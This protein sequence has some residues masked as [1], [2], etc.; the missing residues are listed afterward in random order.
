MTYRFTL[1]YNSV[2]TEVEEPNGWDSFKSE[3]KRDFKSHGVVF[4]YTSGTLK[5]G[6]AD[7]RD[8]LESA[9]QL[10]GFD[11]SVQLAIDQRATEFDSWTN[12]FTGC[13]I[14][15]NR[16]LTELYF[17]V[18]F[19]S[20]TFQQQTVNRLKTKLRLDTT[21]DLDGATLSGSLTSY[22]NTWHTMRVNKLS[23]RNYRSQ[24]TSGQLETQ[25]DTMVGGGGNLTQTAIWNFQ[26]ELI[27]EWETHNTVTEDF[28]DNAIGNNSGDENYTS[29]INGELS[30]SGNIKVRYS[31][32]TSS[33][34]VGTHSTTV[35]WIVRHENS[36]GTEIEE[37]TVSTYQAVEVSTSSMLYDSGIVDTTFSSVS[38]TN[39]VSV[40]DRVFLYTKVLSIFPG[41]ATSTQS[42]ASIDLYHVTQTTWQVLKATENREVKA[43][44]I[45]DVIE[46]MLYI[47]TGVNSRLRSDFLATT[48]NGASEDGCGSLVLLTNGAQLRG[49][50]NAME[51]SLFDILESLS[52]IYGI[53]YGFENLGSSTYALRVE[54]MEY[55]YGDGEILDLGSPVSVDEIDSYKESSFD[56]LA[57]NKVQIGFSKF[58]TDEDESNNIEDF[59]TKS[60]YSL[61]IKTVEG[62]YSKI[63]PLISSGRLIQATFESFDLTKRWKYD[64]SVFIVSAV[65]ALGSF[66][67]EKDQG[68]DIVNGLDDRS[69]AYNLRFAP[70]FMMLNHALIVN[71]VLMGKSFSEVIKNVSAEVSKTF[72]VDYIDYYDCRLGAI[73]NILRTSIGD[74]SI[75]NNYAGL[76]IFDPIQHEI[77]VAMTAT[78][79]NLIIDA[80]EN[81][82]SDSTKDLGYLTYKDSDG[83]TQTGYPMNIMWNP[84]DGIANVTTLERADNYE[85]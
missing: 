4:K 69:T 25:S 26:E 27:K 61:P 24:E 83:N 65:R 28:R 20:S 54:L 38:L 57:F 78:Q 48:E 51:V 82:S 55:F 22:T 45:F 53:G 52:S 64:D 17:S 12:V 56:D 62:S 81:N 49:I 85:V 50:D 39:D 30:F 8:V 11:A 75:E 80:M 9:F 19:E 41:G 18:D 14:M 44:K 79:L 34:A 1:T 60:E 5:L 36:S 66:V 43:F 21:E 77:T 35:T 31:G 63:S 10:E 71:S 32:T 15:K 6:F 3:I 40:N 58:S 73:Q 68:F 29:L 2:D 42:N 72:E 37:I 67:P 70:V 33:N 46:W 23:K 13:A 47:I 74:I 84:N 59:L 16:E 76:R 7:G